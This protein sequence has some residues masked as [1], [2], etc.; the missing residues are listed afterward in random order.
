MK[1]ATAF[2]LGRVSNLPTVCTNALAGMALAGSQLAAGPLALVVLAAAL[3]YTAGMFLNDAFDA[4]IDAQSQRFRPIPAGLVSRSAVFA[5]GY[6][7]LAIS[8]VLLT[9]T[10]LSSGTGWWSALVGLALAATI[11]GYNANHK[12]N[13]FGPV[14]MGLCRVMVYFAAA[15]AVSTTLP[16]PLWIG[17]ALL[18]AH[19]MGLTY[20][21]KREGMG[22]VGRVWPFIC[23]A[24]PLLFGAVVSVTR[25]EIIPFV[26][27]LL[28][29]DAVAI[30]W[31]LRNNPGDIGR[32]IPMLIAAISILDA[33]LIASQ[34]QTVLAA[35]ALFA[36]PLTLLLQRWVR[37]T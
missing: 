15:L 4:D 21:A 24:M 28:A 6:G 34:G 17:A 20:V 32:A 1:L 30:R 13:P 37:G 10:G 27:I 3:A 5:W 14:L 16:A 18:L 22:A 12:E 9:I 33:L 7:M 23:L 11:V 25:P 19:V 8:V 29:A 36:F 31:C 35:L 2:R 26:V